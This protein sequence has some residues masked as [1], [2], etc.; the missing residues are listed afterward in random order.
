MALSSDQRRVL[1]DGTVE[2][3]LCQ[4][5]ERW[6]EWGDGEEEEGEGEEKRRTESVFYYLRLTA[7][8]CSVTRQVRRFPSFPVD[9]WQKVPSLSSRLLAEGISLRTAV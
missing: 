2:G 7:E 6:C 1:M 4:A 8:L 3:H 9:N 5:V